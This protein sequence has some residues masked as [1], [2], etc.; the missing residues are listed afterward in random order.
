MKKL[1]DSF[2]QIWQTWEKKMTTSLAHALFIQ[3]LVLIAALL[4]IP[5]QVQ[6]GFMSFVGDLFKSTPAQAEVADTTPSNSQNMALLHAAVNSDPNP[7][8]GSNDIT[9]VADSALLPETGPTG[10]I[11]DVKEDPINTQISVY[12]V[13]D[14]DSLSKIAQLFNVSVNTILWANDL[15]SGSALKTGQTLV[16]LPVSGIKY[17]VKK[18]DTVEGLAKKYKS[19][20][21]EILS[22]NGLTKGAP[23]EVGS[24]VVI[25]DGELAAVPP[26]VQKGKGAPV[27]ERLI[28]GASG[29]YYPGYY[30]RPIDGGHK[31]QGLHGYNGVDLADS[32]GTPVHAAASGVVIVSR[33]GG[34]N[35]GYGNYVVISHSNG[36]QT[37]Y[38]HLSSNLVSAGQTVSQGQTIGLMGSTGHSTGP[39]VHFE[40]RGAVNPF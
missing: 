14:G 5:F 29:P 10:T 34:W 16:I 37:L 30:I 12:V 36:T 27:Y 22:Y 32:V 31:S 17:T 20:V 9:I 11:A 35:T 26:P 40:I 13:H 39:H 4:I 3:R 6:A 38:A 7:A 28:R 24:E 25:P 18:G 21:D 33:V 19:D 15:P 1:H 8:K 2:S 23:L